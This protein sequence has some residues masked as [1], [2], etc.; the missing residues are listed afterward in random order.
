MGVFDMCLKGQGV[1]QL[2]WFHLLLSEGCCHC[3]A[4]LWKK[5]WNPVSVGVLWSLPQVDTHSMALAASTVAV[6]ALP[7]PLCVLSET[8]STPESAQKAC[9]GMASVWQG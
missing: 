9:K 3:F 5:S 6:H 4:L 7:A 1:L 8:V 2:A